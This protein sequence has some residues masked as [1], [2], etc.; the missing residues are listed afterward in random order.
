VTTGESE[1]NQAQRVAAA[2]KPG[3]RVLEWF[4]RGA[5]LADK[6]RSLPEPSARAS[7]LGRRAQGSADLAL[8]SSDLARNADLARS[9]TT[10]AEPIETVADAVR[11]ELYRQSVYWALCA[12]AA[13]SDDSAGASYGV[14]IWDTLDDQLLSAAVGE[15]RAEAVRSSVRQGSFVYFAELSLAEQQALSVELQKLAEALLGQ[16]NQRSNAL[17]AIVWQRIRRLSLVLLL[18]LLVAAGWAWE[19]KT[20]DERNDLAEGK[21][22]RQSSKLDG[23]CAS[24]KQ[25]CAESPSFFFHTLEEKSPWVELDLGRVERISTVQANNR[26]DCCTERAVPLLVEVS[27]DH[28]QWHTVARRDA[29]FTTWRATFAS[30]DARWVRLRAPRPTFLHL[31]RVRILR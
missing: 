29:A 19:R 27:V 15:H 5:A 26:L 3:K 18:V 30:T 8:E 17:K 22:W 31:A 14:A 9:A 7:V 13:G 4:W 16:V 11:C 10:S 24:P 6:R 12:L 25:V 28:K 21:P 1:S 2:P 20:H 23:G